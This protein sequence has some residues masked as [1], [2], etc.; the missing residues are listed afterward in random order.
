MNKLYYLL[1]AVLILI[2]IMLS[3]GIFFGENSYSKRAELI[4]DNKIQEIQNQ[5]LKRQN[6]ILEFEIKNAQNS[7]DHVENFAREKLNLTYKEEEFISF[8][9]ENKKDDDDE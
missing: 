4:E 2:I 3:K 9:E 5:E 1:I 7:N 6:K 8:K